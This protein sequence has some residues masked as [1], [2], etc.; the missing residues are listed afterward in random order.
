MDDS[1]NQKLNFRD[2]RSKEDENEFLP[3]YFDSIT[4]EEPSTEEKKNVLDN[5]STDRDPKFG[6]YDYQNVRNAKTR[7]LHDLDNVPT[8]ILRETFLKDH[9]NHVK[10][11]RFEQRDLQSHEHT[12][13]EPEAEEETKENVMNSS[14]NLW[15]LESEKELQD[16][17]D[18]YVRSKRSLKNDDTVLKKIAN[19]GTFSFISIM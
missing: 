1:S 11:S 17:K 5:E 16:K 7:L 12:A 13:E 3:E 15:V 10:R 19:V 18:R 2:P 4:T 14:L 9:G 6:I 8:E